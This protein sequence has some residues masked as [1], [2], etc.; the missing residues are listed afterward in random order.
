MPASLIET[1]R[2]TASV[3]PQ[4]SAVE[5][6][7]KTLTYDELDRLS[8]AL[9][10]RLEDEGTERVGLLLGDPLDAVVA[11]VGVL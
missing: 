11:I 6:A 1:I 2:L 8:D 5:T 3:H 9:A 7:G 10:D 4:R